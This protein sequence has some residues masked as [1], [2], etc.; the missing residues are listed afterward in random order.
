MARRYATVLLSAPRVNDVIRHIPADDKVDQERLVVGKCRVD[1]RANLGGFDSDRVDAESARHC[2]ELD[3]RVVEIERGREVSLREIALLPVRVDVELEQP[4]AL[5]VAHH[6]LGADAVVRRGP[7]RLDGVHASAIAAES[8]DGLI[9]P[10]ELDANR[11]RETDAERSATGLEEMSG[12]DRGQIAVQVGR[13]G[14]G[15][16]EDDRVRR[17]FAAELVHEACRMHRDGVSGLQIGRALGCLL[18]LLSAGHCL[19]ARRRRPLLGDRHHAI[20]S[21]G[22]PR[23]R[24]LGIGDDADV[25][26]EVLGNLARVEVNVNDP[27]SGG[28][29]TGERREDLGK[30]IGAADEDNV[31]ALSDGPALLSE[32]VAQQPLELRMTGVHV[33]FRGIGAPHLGPHKLCYSR[34][35]SLGPGCR[36]PVADDDDR[37][38]GRRQE[39]GDVVDRLLFGTHSRQGH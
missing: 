37:T 27:R 12:P 13:A 26:R 2:I 31:R 8:D 11:S 7:E 29:D 21:L 4:V 16:V 39:T 1:G 10:A 15:F 35:L 18:A 9:G 32:H 3:H 19:D 20:Q 28:K 33:D 5:V 38:D 6:E 14:E 24:H 34:Q 23:Q 25:D 17:Q 30:D 22:D 36:D